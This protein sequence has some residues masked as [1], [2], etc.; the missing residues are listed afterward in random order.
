MRVPALAHQSRR[1]GAS[2]HDGREPPSSGE[3]GFSAADFPAR[4]LLRGASAHEVVAKLHR[5][6]P[7][8]LM[9]RCAER[10]R[11]QAL[12]L[13]V[14]RLYLR[15]IAR[16]AFAAGNYRGVPPL[17]A[18]IAQV[19]RLAQKELLSEDCEAE[20]TEFSPEVD[21]DPR[22]AFVSRTLG[23]EPALARRGVN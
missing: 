21:R 19:M 22:H 13:Q 18:W 6:D 14:D 4:D 15:T 5:G 9:A 20:R 12:L 1:V 17:D 7:L 8:E 16:M 10:V 3:H 2:H 11:N 23:V